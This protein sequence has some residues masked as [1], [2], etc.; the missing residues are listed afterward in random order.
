MASQT[1]RIII[2]DTTLRDGEQS[3]GVAFS[4]E[5]QIQIARRLDAIGVPELEVGVP[6]MGEEEREVIAALAAEKLDAGL[7]VWCRMHEDDLAAAQGLGV[8]LIDLSSPVSDQHIEKKLRQSREWSLAQIERIVPMAV[9]QGF[10][11]CLGGEDSSRADMD[12]LKRVLETAQRAGAERFRFADTVGVMEP[13][14]VMERFAELRRSTDLDL[15]MH[16]HDDLGL[17]TA[18]S[19]AAVRGGATYVNTTV[20]GIG[21]RAGNAPLEEL[22]VGL[23]TLYG[24]ETGVDLS[25]YRA[26]SDLVADAAGMSVS[27][28]KSLVGEKVFSHESGIHVDGLLKDPANYQGVDPARLGRGHSFILGKHSGAQGVI[29]AYAQI[30]VALEREEARRLLPMIR[31]FCETAKR[32]PQAAE[33][34]AFQNGGTA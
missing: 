2:N 20:L 33:L 3:A 17:A 24:Y 15:E 12:F 21:E 26:V 1:R 8:D 28:I 34:A 6:A 27:P 9:D 19:L 31:K 29:H 5:E 18:N 22:V 25:D 23:D 13:F 7:M 4:T 30:G 32:S 11:V 10:R 16:A 14:G